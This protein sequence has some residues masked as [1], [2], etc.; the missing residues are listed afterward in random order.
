[1]PFQEAAPIDS[2]R[3]PRPN[4]ALC[5][6]FVLRVTVIGLL[7]V[8]ALAC[9]RTRKPS[10]PVTR[11]PTLPA[12]QVPEYLR[13]S[14]FERVDLVDTDPLVVSGYGLVV[15]LHDTGDN[16]Q[17]PT[18]VREYMIR[19]MV[20]RGFG[21]KLQPGFEHLTPEGVL[22]DPRTAIVRVD[23]IVPPGARKGD[24]ID[25]RVVALPTSATTSLAHGE[26]YRTELKIGGANPNAPGVAIDAI[27]VAQ[28]AIFVN[29][30]YALKTPDDAAARRSLRA[31]WI[32]DG[33]QVQESRPLVLRL[34][35]PERRIARLIEHRVDGRF[36]NLK[37]MQRDKIAAAQDEA[38]VRVVIPDL[39][40]GDWEH[41]SG[42]M[43]H[44]F[45]DTSP[46]FVVFK[47]RQL[48]EEAVKPD[49]MLLNISYCWEGLGPGALPAITPLM[50]HE[51]P[52]VAFAAAR[53]AAFLGDP[54]APQALATMA[55]NSSHPFQLNAIAALGELPPSPVVASLLREILDGDQA[56]A[57]IEAY[58]VLAR[59]RDPMIASRVINER[60]ILDVVPCGG[61]PLIFATRSG[62]PRVALIGPR[63]SLATP[64]NFTAM[65]DRLTLLGDAPD[66]G[67]TVYYRP[68]TDDSPVKF[69]SRA[70]LAE[71]IARL[72]GDPTAGAARLRFSYGD[73]VAIVQALCDKQQIVAPV[74]KA[75]VPAAFVFQPA[76]GLA[77]AI[78]DA[79]QIPEQERPAGD[80]AAPQPSAVSVDEG[81]PN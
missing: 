3:A 77:E 65:D 31:G 32:L 12:K 24:S 48:A 38:I 44:L 6:A 16:A 33:G 52:E 30:A 50:T 67:I 79:P 46:Q 37:K 51:R 15:N 58:R 26:L 54:A 9:N 29:P 19:E 39:F 57:R 70:D 36:A 60:F 8:G 47:S 53:A 7:V 78:L 27:A 43:T 73:V 55:R 49:A 68:P 34:R 45:F 75:P 5:P 2:R 25:V 10:A 4:A 64:F 61:P 11:Y 28:G 21:S 71:L 56:M 66:R 18:A 20:K 13:G 63:P 81:R 42:V 41:F 76:P 14:I 1:M 17:V 23:A 72:G 62:M 59:Q 22:R 80:G 35:Q 69:V 74:G 40:T